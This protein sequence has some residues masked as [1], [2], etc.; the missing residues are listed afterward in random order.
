MDKLMQ[1]ELLHDGYVVMTLIM[2]N[3]LPITIMGKILA[4]LVCDVHFG[5]ALL[6]I[7]R[8]SFCCVVSEVVA[9]T[10]ITRMFSLCRCRVGQVIFQCQCHCP[11][12]GL[13]RR[14]EVPKL[15]KHETDLKCQ[16]PRALP[17]NYWVLFTRIGMLALRASLS[18][19]SGN[20]SLYCTTS[21]VCAMELD[22]LFTP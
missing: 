13:L 17:W 15:C 3:P 22:L 21:N 5:D 9:R 1:G 14:A 18:Y 16:F 8:Y 11:S 12:L 10:S 4:W 19:W 6:E 7:F 2:I 20:L